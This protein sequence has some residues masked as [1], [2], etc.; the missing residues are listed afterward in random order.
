METQITHQKKEKDNSNL[1]FLD[2]LEEFRI[3]LIRVIISFVVFTIIAYVFR[4]EIFDFLTEPMMGLD[5]KFIH[6]KVYD[7]FLAYL[8]ISLYAGIFVSV[9]YLVYELSQFV[10]PA[11]Y[12]SERRLYYYSLVIII[13][14]FFTGAFFS[15]KFLTPVSLQ[16]LIEFDKEETKKVDPKKLKPPFDVKK[17]LTDINNKLADVNNHLKKSIDKYPG[18][19]E[20]LV[21]I[22]KSLTLIYQD[23]TKL[24]EHILDKSKKEKKRKIESFLSISEYLDWVVFF[25]LAIG[26]VFQL[27]LVLALLAK[28]GIINDAHLIKFRPYSVVI[29]LVVAAI[30]TP[31]P[32]VFTQLMV[33]VPVYILYEL[34]V[35]AARIIRKRKEK[36]ELA[37]S[38]D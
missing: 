16:F 35:I 33:A 22:N 11:L 17:N 18:D 24:N 15:F 31:T 14:L 34:S 23:F 26:L 13:I 8:K 25:I 6:L 1:P 32:D 30:I 12:E 3:R 21:R 37:N 10:L 5:I 4:E 2:H 28:I 9:P 38:S 36:E 19:S 27:P 29:I 20:Q 7:K